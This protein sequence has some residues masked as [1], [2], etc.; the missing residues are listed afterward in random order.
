MEYLPIPVR[1]FLI[2][3]ENKTKPP[4]VVPIWPTYQY[5]YSLFQEILMIRRGFLCINSYKTKYFEVNGQRAEKYA[6]IFL[7]GEKNTWN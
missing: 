4:L 7:N 5:Q 6:K 1:I 3:Y 2:T